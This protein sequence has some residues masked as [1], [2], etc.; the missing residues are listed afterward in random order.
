[1][2]AAGSLSAGSA[3]AAHLAVA[4]AGTPSEFGGLVEPYRRELL[5]Y[6]YRLLGSPLD[7]E[8]LVQETLLRAWRGRAGFNRVG[9]FRAWLYKIATNA[10]LNALARRPR[11]RLPARTDPPTDPAQWTSGLGTTSIRRRV[12]D[13]Q[14]Q[15]NWQ[16]RSGGG[17][18]FEASW[19]LNTW[20]SADTGAF[21]ADDLK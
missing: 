11:R 18:Q 6:G 21:M 9:S 19:P 2:S 20:L 17:V 8:D 16:A 3:E 10:G 4:Q 15:C 1:M 14:G 12:Y 5:A 13:L 7:A